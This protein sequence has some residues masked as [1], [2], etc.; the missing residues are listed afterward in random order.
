MKL[1]CP[2]SGLQLFTQ[3]GWHGRRLGENFTANF[4][5]IGRS[6]LYSSPSG[7]ADLQSSTAVLRLSGEVARQV[8]DG[9]GGYV[10]IEDYAAFDN[11][12]IDAR[13][14]FID[15]M[16]SRDRVLTVIF[17]N[18]SNLLNLFVKIGKRFNTTGKS[19]YVVR[20]YKEAISL[21]LR[22]CDKHNLDKGSFVFGKQAAYRAG[23][24]SV[25]PVELLSDSHWDIKT[26]DFTNRC[27]VL[28]RCL[29]HSV[30]TGFF[31]EAYVPLVDRMRRSVRDT[32]SSDESLDY[33]VVDVSELKG[34]SRKARQLYMKS[35]K[36]WHE[37]FPFRMYIIYG[38]NVFMTTAFRLAK[39]FVSFRAVVAR[40]IDHAF[41]LIQADKNSKNLKNEKKSTGKPDP[42]QGYVEDI[43]TYIGGI[44]WE[45]E[46]IDGF[47]DTA[48]RDHPFYIVFQAIKLIKDELDDLF[49]TREQIQ[50]NLVE[51]EKKYRD[52]FEKGSDLLCFHDLEG[53]L[54]D[55]NI[56]FKRGYGWDGEMPPGINIRD[57][58]PERY[59]RGFDDYLDRIKSQG[60]D[61]GIMKFTTA[62]GREITLEYNNVLVKDNSGNPI[63]I[64]GSARDITNRI[65]AEH[66]SR[67]L[68]EQL[69]QKHKM[70]A[71]GTL[72]GG[73]AHEFNNILGI[74][75]GNTE[76]AI[77][78]VPDWNPAKEYLEE[79][80]SASLRAK[81][82]VRHILSFAR[83]S[84]AQRKPLQVSLVIRESIKLMRATIP[85][86]IEIHREIMCESEIVLADPTEIS[87]VFMNL[88]TNSVHAMGEGP[89]VLEV[90]LETV[91]LDEV[92]KKQYE[93]L[94]PGKFVKLTVEDTGHG[95]KPEIMDRIFDPYFTTKDVDQGL[96]LGLSIA[97]GIVKKH[98]GA[99]NVS[100]SVGK[101][102]VIEVLFPVIQEKLKP[103]DFIKPGD[104]PTGTESILFVDDE[105][106]IAI[107]AK[108]ILERLGYRVVTQTNPEEAL[109]RF[110]EN[111]ERFD[112]VITDMA[113]PQM[114]GAMFVKEI[115]KI[116]ANTP[117]VLCTGYS[118][119]LDE[120]RAKE[121][122][123]KAYIMKP[124]MRR[125][126]AE[127]IRKVLDR[128]KTLR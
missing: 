37:R 42:I 103:E 76:L 122:G 77:D 46:G 60:H 110:K 3:D 43:L 99:I 124:I 15:Q 7:T 28:D 102:T 54:I 58:I 29:L 63:G 117:I 31:Q 19:I 17:C 127:I 70:E 44:D 36:D 105:V 109:N 55:T 35:L 83:K 51:S 2:V 59:R 47:S 18:L 120:N 95:I 67:K 45:R 81:D 106:S 69:K 121:L 73:I 112:L 108:E 24:R 22:L 82:V 8:A 5:I 96:G 53:R 52:L 50:A 64:R 16:S 90:R 10:Q 111:P 92:S 12:T 38:A 88:C 79:I 97:Y 13:K 11:A 20:D 116:R 49:R 25:I 65:E 27:V 98:D 80:R 48:D 23:S 72:S 56:A 123:I 14:H 66:E 101:G 114:S 84:P 6:V 118:E 4:Y 74:I 71:I 61:E 62:A 107:L 104:L 21:A 115:M 75:I 94:K 78:D 128:I 68:Q 30:S 41:E 33:V 39:P 26:D 32:L 85:T 126:L 100:S 34:G 9:T 91:T 119:Q 93:G 86:T 125:N 40:D 89:G 57:L 1:F 87:Q 113:M